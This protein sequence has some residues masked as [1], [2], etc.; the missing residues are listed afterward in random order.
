MFASLTNRTFMTRAAPQRLVR[1]GADPTA[2]A[3]SMPTA[4]ATTAPGPDAPPGTY[5]MGHETAAIAPSTTD[6]VADALPWAGSLVGLVS[7]AL[8]GYAR[9]GVLPLLGYGVLGNFL[10]AGAGMIVGSLIKHPTQ[11]PGTSGLT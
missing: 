6:R 5:P 10:G 4:P 2:P 3:P 9:G 11:A 8:F 7:G 1:V